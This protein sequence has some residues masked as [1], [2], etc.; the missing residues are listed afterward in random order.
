[1]HKL[2][3]K[4]NGKKPNQVK[5]NQ[6]LKVGGVEYVQVSSI[7]CFGEQMTEKI[8]PIRFRMANQSEKQNFKS[9]LGKLK[10]MAHV[11][12]RISITTN[13]TQEE[14]NEIRQYVEE[15]KE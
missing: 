3:E 14:R 10:N 13:Y 8:R 12:R 7:V 4:N 1:M 2:K 6:L 9:M 5:I 15:A 11:F